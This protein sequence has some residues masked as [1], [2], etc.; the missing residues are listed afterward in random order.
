M[1]WLS[2]N[3]IKFGIKR[4]LYELEHNAKGKNLIYNAKTKEYV[5]HIDERQKSFVQSPTYTISKLEF[6]VYGERNDNNNFNSRTLYGDSDNW[7]L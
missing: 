3:D 2:Y 1:K 7:D 6:D 4:K 5:G